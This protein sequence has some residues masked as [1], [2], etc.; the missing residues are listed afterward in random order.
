MFIRRHGDTPETYARDR[1][2]HLRLQA[3]LEGWTRRE[4]ELVVKF[5]RKVC[6]EAGEQ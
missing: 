5:V 1:I 2:T 4:L 3:K 6:A